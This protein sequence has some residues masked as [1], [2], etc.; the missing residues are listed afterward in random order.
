MAASR[1]AQL[2][3]RRQL[4][5]GLT[6]SPIRLKEAADLAT[7]MATAAR[8]VEAARSAL[9]RAR[10]RL[11]DAWRRQHGHSHGVNENDQGARKNGARAASV[12]PLEWVP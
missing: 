12:R 10:D 6:P 7:A 9:D 3:E 8:D 1:P 4:V 2:E 11:S 5:A